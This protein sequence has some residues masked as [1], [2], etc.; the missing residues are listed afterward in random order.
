MTRFIVLATLGAFLGGCSGAA[1]PGD[2][3]PATIGL[4]EAGFRSV[5]ARTAA[6]VPGPLNG[7]T[8]TGTVTV[9]RGPSCHYEANADAFFTASGTATGPYPGT[10]T[11]SGHWWSV[12]DSGSFFIWAF[13]ES[14][15]IASL[16]GSIGGFVN[17]G[18]QYSGGPGPRIPLLRCTIFGPAGRKSDMT[19]STVPPALSSSASG[20]LRVDRIRNGREFIEEFF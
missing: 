4:P 20:A 7:E 19:Y 15:T 17:V 13:E 14:F 10:F 3:T 6:S 18:A 11:A 1:R 9:Q 8:F 5:S 12:N 2:V 16:G